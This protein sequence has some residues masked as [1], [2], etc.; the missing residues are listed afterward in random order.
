[1]PPDQLECTIIAMQSPFLDHYVVY[2]R[3]SWC[4]FFSRQIDWVQLD[5]EAVSPRAAC[6]RKLRP[7]AALPPG[8]SYR[9][10]SEITVTGVGFAPPDLFPALPA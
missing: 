9:S 7:P 4:D 2:D 10:L 6:G 1:M 8:S 3:T 5:Y